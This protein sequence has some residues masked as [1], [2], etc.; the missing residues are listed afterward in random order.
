MTFQLHAAEAVKRYRQ[1]A[2][3]IQVPAR[4]LTVTG[5]RFQGIKQHK[6]KQAR[7]K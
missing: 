3:K 5:L 4:A 2:T 6:E 1:V 7:R